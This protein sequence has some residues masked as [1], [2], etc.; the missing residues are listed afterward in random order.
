MNQYKIESDRIDGMAQ[1]SI[2]SASDFAEGTNLDALI[3]GGFITVA[4][5]RAA[6]KTPII[7]EEK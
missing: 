3:E 7:S 5:K 2:V 4:S 6:E 1:G